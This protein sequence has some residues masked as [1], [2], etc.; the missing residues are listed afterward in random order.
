M[1]FTSILYRNKIIASKWSSMARCRLEWRGS[2]SLNCPLQM[3]D[4]LR[5]ACFWSTPLF[6]SRRAVIIDAAGERHEEARASVAESL[7]QLP[8]RESLQHCDG[9]SPAP[10]RRL[11]PLLSLR[12]GTSTQG[13]ADEQSAK[14]SRVL[15]W[16]PCYGREYWF[17][18]FI[19]E[20]RITD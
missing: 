18:F 17:V 13:A 7:A 16:L 9:S 15:D 10:L 3:E 19:V 14:F 4:V 20:D 5:K 8:G 11:L 2:V 1:C 12:Q 6:P